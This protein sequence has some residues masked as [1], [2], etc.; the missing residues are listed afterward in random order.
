MSTQDKLAEALR[1]MTSFAQ[2]MKHPPFGTIANAAAALAAYDS[3]AAGGNGVPEG[4]EL[5]AV[6]D[7]F[8]DLMARLSD[9]D[10][11]GDMP[12]HIKEVFDW[13]EYKH[14]AAAPSPQEPK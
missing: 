10:R 7:Q 14:L 9:F 8:E 13:F 2:H 6:N 11:R 12:D 4:M 5:I 1:E 3:D